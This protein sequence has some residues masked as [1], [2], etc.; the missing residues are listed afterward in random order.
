M[1]DRLFACS[2]YISWVVRCIKRYLYSTISIRKVSYG[3]SSIGSAVGIA[4]FIVEGRVCDSSEKARLNGTF[5][6]CR[7]GIQEI[8]LLVWLTSVEDVPVCAQ[9]KEE[10][11]SVHSK[12]DD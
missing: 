2:D 7:V 5:V 1:S 4:G 10:E 9:L 12:H 3:S 6:G 11:A 8:G